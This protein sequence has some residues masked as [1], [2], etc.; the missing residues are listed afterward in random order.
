MNRNPVFV[1]TRR[2]QLAVIVSLAWP[3]GTINKEILLTR[4]EYSDH[5]PREWRAPLTSLLGTPYEARDLSVEPALR[6]EPSDRV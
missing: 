2:P 3:D 4:R 6:A 1:C 5:D